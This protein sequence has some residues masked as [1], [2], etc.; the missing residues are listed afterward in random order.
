MEQDT[1][2]SIQH[3]DG[4]HLIDFNRASHPLIE[5]ITAPQI[6]HPATAA[7][8]VRKVQGLLKSVDAVTA[9]MEMGGL[10]ADVNISV[11]RK[12][13]NGM[14]SIRGREVWPRR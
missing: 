10:R 14:V 9:G 1:A 8:L 2:K 6:H 13:Q 4:V 5:I 12:R 11:R 3:G 7:A